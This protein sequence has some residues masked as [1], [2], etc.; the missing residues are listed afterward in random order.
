[1]SRKATGQALILVV[2]SL[3]VLC[4]G[5]VVLFDTGQVVTKKVQLVNTADAAAYSA[6]VQEA[7]ALN[8]IAYMNR[9]SVANEVAMAQMVSWYSWTN[10]AISATDHMKDAL[11]V[12]AIVTIFFGVG[13]VIEGAVEALQEAKTGLEEGRNVEQE[14]FDAAAMAVADLNGVYAD[15]SEVVAVGA[16]A[17]ASNVA[18]NVVTLNDSQ[19]SIPTMGI[20]ILAQD[21]LAASAYVTRY[22]IPS[23]GSSGNAGA[24]RLKNV[25]M[26]ARDPFSRQRDGSFLFGW[27]KKYGGTDLANYH[28][29]VGLDTLDI[30]FTCPAFICGLTGFPP[31]EVKFD[32]PIAWGGGAGVDN[33]AASFSSLARQDPGWSGPYQGN[34]PQYATNQRYAPYSGALSNGEAS[35]LA[36]SQPTEDGEPWIKPFFETPGATVGLPD[37][38]DILA[39]KAT[40]PYDNGKSAS[41]NGVSVM[42]EGPIFT[43]LVAQAMN[44]VQTSSNVSGIGGPPDF[45]TTDQAVSN[46]ITAMASA[47]TYFSRPRSLFPRLTDPER[48]IGSLFSPYWQARLIDTK[49]TIRQEVAISN[50]AGAP[51]I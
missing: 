11:Q 35:G 16:A 12:I 31:H 18:R 21:T 50:G 45:Q 41:A 4:L 30:E 40:V 38:N 9:A 23:N 48:E 29:W 28:S 5:L 25:V 17:D 13:E 19:A 1:M 15:M 39:N 6:A 8:V 32:T 14:L 27:I 44:T 42:D 22:T 2:V 49:C 20:G 46:G 3:L 7:R 33:V 10:F 26:E 37:Y 47:Q 51:C 24:E 43:V 34:D 36:L